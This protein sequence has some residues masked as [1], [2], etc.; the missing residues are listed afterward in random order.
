MIFD[1]QVGRNQA[2]LPVVGVQH[3]DVQVQQAD[4][5]QHGAAEEDEP[6]AVVDVVLAVDAVELVAV[7]V[8]VLL[9]QID[10]HLAAGHRA[11]EQMAGDHLAAD[12][13]DEVDPQRLDRLAAVAASG[14][15]RAG[16]PPPDGRAGPTRSAARRRRRP[17]RRSWQTAPLRSWPA[18][19]SQSPPTL[20]SPIPTPHGL[21][22]VPVARRCRWGGSCT[23]TLIRA[24]GDYRRSAQSA[25][26]KLYAIVNPYLVSQMPGYSTFTP[27]YV[28]YQE[29]RAHS[30]PGLRYRYNRNIAGQD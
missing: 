5:L 1:L 17:I 6:L 12:G 16:S 11:P 30:L 26:G 9:D 15:R 22:A 23:A 7:E 19:Y 18:G 2:G 8:L 13:H 4:G 21:S 14:D 28:C 24:S 10:R 29:I 25:K 3:V 20:R 27:I